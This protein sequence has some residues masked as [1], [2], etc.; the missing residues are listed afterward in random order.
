MNDSRPEML[1]RAFAHPAVML[2]M[3]VLPQLLLAWLNISDCLRLFDVLEPTRWD[4]LFLL[5]AF[6][7]TLL[8]GGLLLTALAW[9]NRRPIPLGGMVAW[10]LASVAYTVFAT[11]LAADLFDANTAFW[12]SGV[13]ALGSRQA[14]LVLPGAFLAGLRVACMLLPVSPKRDTSIALAVLVGIPVGY[15]LAANLFSSLWR[16]AFSEALLMVIFP[17]L[18]L[19]VVL[20]LIRVTALTVRHWTP[21]PGHPMRLGWLGIFGLFAPIGGLFLNREIPFPFNF[22]NPLFYGLALLN[23]LLLLLPEPATPGARRALWF[24]R[25]AF[26]P[27]VTYFFLLFLPFLPFFL[28]ALFVFAAGLLILAPTALFL[29]QGAL[30]WEGLAE[31]ARTLGRA[32]ALVHL[33]LALSVL[34]AAFVGQAL[35][36][37]V[38]LHRALDYVYPGDN[39]IP[40]E[41]HGSRFALR[42]SLDAVARA[43]AEV[44]LPFL[45]SWQDELVFDGLVLP[46]RKLADLHRIFFNEPPPTFEKDGRDWSLF[47]DGGSRRNRGRWGRGT[48][49]PTTAELVQVDW[50]E[51]LTNGARRVTADIRM[52][53]PST[54]QSEYATTLQLPPGGL[55]TGFWLYIGEERV[56]SAIH[57]RKTALWVYNT[58]RDRTRRDPGI[59]HYRPDGTVEFRVFPFEAGQT[60]R[61]VI[62]FT[63]PAAVSGPLAVGTATHLPAVARR[64]GL[65]VVRGAQAGL[66]VVAGPDAPLPRLRREPAVRILVDVSSPDTWEASL[67]TAVQQA[68]E[69]HGAR[70]LDVTLVGETAVDLAPGLPAEEEPVL[71]AARKARPANPGGF[72][73]GRA[74]R[75]AVWSYLAQCAAPDPGPAL[76]RPLI[77]VAGDMA[78]GVQ[79]DEEWIRLR[80]LVPDL[81]VLSATNA[82]FTPPEVVLLRVDSQTLAAAAEPGGLQQ[83]FPGA[84][85]DAGVEVFDP[86]QGK[87]LP[88]PATL[89][90]PSPT[91][92]FALGTDLWLD[93]LRADTG[94]QDARL[95]LSE[96][97][98]A[99]RGSRVLLP[100]TSFIVVEQAAQWQALKE[101]EAK[102]LAG[103]TAFEPDDPTDT[104]EP[105]AWVWA[106]ILAGGW[107]WRRRNQGT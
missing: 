4:K 37:R 52:H 44:S 87:F 75:R 26:F 5:T 81:A 46:E 78:T 18:A 57:E 8:A 1:P 95:N 99:S 66:R 91:G 58:I 77:L 9:A 98:A 47:S 100:S 12:L 28:P 60:R 50:Q 6:Q 67:R 17:L 74:V 22:Q 80:T 76:R 101:T 16:G 63:L 21:G 25:V 72:F 42:L 70:T 85:K 48:P 41:F 53:N 64:D 102:K 73:L 51:S 82:V 27:Y 45:S 104:P 92:A 13:D 24:L 7:F 55:I 54:V 107:A 106:L 15:Y 38:T 56:P 35:W 97:V 23:G 68:R 79:A 40:A 10:L 65:Q 93:Q 34:P 30:I 86:S 32:R 62:E 83:C 49:P 59:L 19:I 3:A 2:G 36:Q 71:A 31:Q 96:R 94:V 20:A 89:L 90:L 103:H 43:R 69:T 33:A 14:F 11:R 88:L 105:P 39:R 84:A 29:I 61:A